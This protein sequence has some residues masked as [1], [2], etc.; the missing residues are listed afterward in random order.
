MSLGG[1]YSLTKDVKDQ[2][3]QDTMIIL[4]KKWELYKTGSFG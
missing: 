1:L 3:N 4:G 2:N